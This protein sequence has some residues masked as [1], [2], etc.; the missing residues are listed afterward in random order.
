MK[1][2]N[3]IQEQIHMEHVPMRQS[4]IALSDN[5]SAKLADLDRASFEYT[6]GIS[7]DETLF[8]RSLAHSITEDVCRDRGVSV[9]KT[10]QLKKQVEEGTYEPDPMAIPVL[11]QLC[12][13]LEQLCQ[14]EADKLTVISADRPDQLESLLND[15]NMLLLQLRG[16]DKKRS[17]LLRR[18]GLE[19]LTFRQIL[20]Q[21]DSEEAVALLSPILERLSSQAEKLKKIKGGTDRL[22]RIRMKQ[23]EQ[24]LSGAKQSDPHVYDKYV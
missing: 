5:I 4:N 2:Q 14:V 12:T 7:A 24:R 19:G 17:D 9:E 3:F 6:E 16:L 13:V 23:L 18:S 8:A 20:M 21:E 10:A 1:I 11:E 15:E 22:I